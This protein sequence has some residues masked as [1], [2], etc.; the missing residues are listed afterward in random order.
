MERFQHPACLVKKAQ[1][2]RTPSSRFWCSVDCRSLWFLQPHLS[3]IALIYLQEGEQ[4]HTHT[5]TH[6]HTHTWA[7]RPHCHM[8]PD[9]VRRK[10]ESSSWR[11]SSMVNHV[12]CDIFPCFVP[13]THRC[14]KW[15]LCC[16]I[17][18]MMSLLLAKLLGIE[19]ARCRLERR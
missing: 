19:A 4:T 2:S 18:A 8:M 10:G 17:C 6:I 14:C 9:S 16:K 11:S 12:H 7:R 5:H 3:R 15:E 13:F 1:W